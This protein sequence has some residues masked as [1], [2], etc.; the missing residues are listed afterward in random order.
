MDYPCFQDLIQTIH[1]ETE[2]WTISGPNSGTI[3]YFGSKM[4]VLCHSWEK[5]LPQIG[6]DA[7]FLWFSFSNVVKFGS[8]LIIIG[9][10]DSTGITTGKWDCSWALFWKV[11]NFSIIPS[12]IDE[13]LHGSWVLWW[14]VFG[15]PRIDRL[16][17][18]F[19]PWDSADGILWEFWRS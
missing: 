2:K 19:G 8:N 13:V 18:I 7:P 11:L 4:K 1:S 15:K 14:F 5:V 6:Q 9:S 3:W 12:A 17:F 10:L 16:F